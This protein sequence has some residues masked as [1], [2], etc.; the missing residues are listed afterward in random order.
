MAQHVL[1]GGITSYHRLVSAVVISLVLMLLQVAVYKLTGLKRQFHAL[2]YGP[3]LFLIAFLSDII[4]KDNG[5]ISSC[6]SCWVYLILIIVWIILVMLGHMMQEIEDKD[7]VRL[8]SRPMWINMLFMAIMFMCVAWMANTNAVFHYRIKVEQCLLDG[9]TSGA[10]QVGKKSLE[11]D[12]NLMMLRMFALSKD[13]QLGEHLFEYPII[14]NS[15]Y[16]LPTD[17]ST[18]MMMYPVNDLYKLLGGR[19]AT[20]MQP[21]HFLELLQH[22]DSLKNQPVND[23]LLCG[24][25]IDRQLDRF[26]KELK[27][28]YQ[29]NDSLPKHY[30]EALT[31]YAHLRSNPQVLYKHNTME[32]DFSNLLQL[33]K[34]YNDY[35][36]RKGKV[37]EQYRGTYWYYYKYEK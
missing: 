11:S 12:E 15:D 33:E 9:D 10:L 26:V 24:Y 37:E 21:M 34:Q 30:R 4:Q 20:I 31:I 17:S 32:E 29:I 18:H 14:G 3:S 5:E 16:I 7:A 23:Y 27:R 35:T 25:L 1:S 36:E 28:C 2:S 22:R 19:P 6:S 8:F 13:N